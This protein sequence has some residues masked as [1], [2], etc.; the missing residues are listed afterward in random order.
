MFPRK[1]KWIQKPPQCVCYIFQINCLTFQY[2]KAKRTVAIQQQTLYKNRVKYKPFETFFLPPKINF[3]QSLFWHVI[4]VSVRYRS[5]TIIFLERFNH[6]NTIGLPTFL[7]HPAP[8]CSP[9][10]YPGWMS[11]S[12]PLPSLG[13]TVRTG[14]KSFGFSTDGAAYQQCSWTKTIHPTPLGTHPDW[15]QDKRTDIIAEGSR[16]SQTWEQQRADLPDSHSSREAY[17]LCSPH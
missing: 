11:C 3:H 2:F 7:L 6:F 10:P 1:K 14:P 12:T 9:L 4:I 13:C 5:I 15:E 17:G 16:I 8:K